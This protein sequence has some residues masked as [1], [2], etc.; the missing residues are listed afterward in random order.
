MP[1][2]EGTYEAEGEGKID[3]TLSPMEHTIRPQSH[4]ESHRYNNEQQ[5]YRRESAMPQY[6]GTYDAADAQNNNS[7]GYT[8]SPLEHKG[9]TQTYEG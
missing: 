7:M 1:Q 9:W 5:Y 6:E 8:N 2:F 4:E 3:Y